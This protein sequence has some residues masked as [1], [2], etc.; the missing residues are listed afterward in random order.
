MTIINSAHPNL[1]EAM[2]ERGRQH[3]ADTLMLL[4]T[5]REA[6]RLAETLPGPEAREIEDLLSACLLSAQRTL[7]TLGETRA[8]LHEF[9]MNVRLTAQQNLL[10]ER[11]NGHRQ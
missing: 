9:N 1:V 2:T 3:Q 7:D 5:L 10:K 6:A 8:E 11:D 4:M